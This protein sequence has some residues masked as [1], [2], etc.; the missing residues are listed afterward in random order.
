MGVHRGRQRHR[1]QPR[2]R[3]AHLRR[4]Q[5]SARRRTVSRHGHRIGHLRPHRKALRRPHLGRRTSRRRRDVLLYSS[6][7]DESM[8]TSL[9]VLIAEDNPGDARLIRMALTEA[10]WT[11]PPRVVTNG[12]DAIAYFA[13]AR[14]DLVILDLNLPRYTGAEVLKS[15]R[16]RPES[17]AI[18]V[19]I[20]SSSPEDIMRAKVRSEAVEA[21]CYLTKPAD[22]DEFLAL[23]AIIRRC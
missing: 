12:E 10:G 2:F 3:R 11:T 16:D 8:T 18:P 7:R 5:T 23:G 19:V 22:I 6:R 4:V 20:L 21:N 15:I 14:P 9:H 13:S 17:R 1:L